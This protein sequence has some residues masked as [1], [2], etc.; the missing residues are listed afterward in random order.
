MLTYRYVSLAFI[1]ISCFIVIGYLF[2][3]ISL[4]FLLFPAAMFIFICF[5][6]SAFICSGFY[7]K[8][9]CRDVQKRGKNVYIT[10]DDSPDENE[11]PLV[12]D[13]L[14]KYD[15]KATFFIIGEKGKKNIEI[16]K[17]ISDQGH[18]LGNHS[19]SHRNFFPLKSRKKIIEEIERT[20]AI[21]K[22]VKPTEG[23]YFRPPFGVTNPP[24]AK[25]IKRLN[26]CTIGWSLKSLDTVIKDHDK[27]LKRLIRNT[28][29][30]YIVLLH[31]PVKNIH[32]VLD[33]YIEYLKKNNY[34]FD[35]VD[36]LVTGNG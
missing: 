30:G 28:R 2:Y 1:L 31:D 16:L 29:P 19:Y 14:K 17:K 3:D 6:G 12:L 25:A 5:L 23:I 11:T 34:N 24:V 10:F 32:V 36:K 8:A 4:L 33:K 13:V 7:T 9:I 20:D 26:T 35:T 27:L 21:I 15:V 18:V 22:S